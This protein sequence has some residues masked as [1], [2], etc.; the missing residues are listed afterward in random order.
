M[1]HIQAMINS[2][3]GHYLPTIVVYGPRG[4]G[5]STAVRIAVNQSK[6]KRPVL[7]ARVTAANIVE[8]KNFVQQV[9]FTIIDAAIQKLSTKPTSVSVPRG[10]RSSS[11]LTGALRQ[12]KQ[13]PIIV[14]E[15]NMKLLHSN[16]SSS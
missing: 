15:V 12:V 13:L 4:S 7:L 11:I 1:E 2:L 9:A 3:S 16:C 6:E 10:I 8:G 5:K 14:L